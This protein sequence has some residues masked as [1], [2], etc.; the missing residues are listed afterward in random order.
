MIG[1]TDIKLKR[2][3]SKHER[4]IRQLVLFS[5]SWS[6]L[7]IEKTLILLS[8]KSFSF[9]FLFLSWKKNGR[10]PEKRTYLFFLT[11]LVQ[12]FFIFSKSAEDWK[13]TLFYF[14]KKDQLLGI[15]W[16]FLKFY[17][18]Y[19][20]GQN[21]FCSRQVSFEINSSVCALLEVPVSSLNLKLKKHWAWTVVGWETDRELL[22]LL[23]W[24]WKS[25]L[26]R[27]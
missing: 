16:L 18:N 6:G 12:L 15:G 14:W 7:K 8:K 11:M 21:I 19:I 5:N 24:V 1:M 4:E 3:G 22:M 25:M 9:P 2:I 27:V 20:F 17:S 10:Q 13:I 26:V 23:V